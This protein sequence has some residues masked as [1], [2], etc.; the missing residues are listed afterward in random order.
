MKTDQILIVGAGAIGAF[1]GALLAKAGADVSVVCRSD[2]ETVKQ[3]GYQINSTLGRWN[4]KPSQ[5]LQ[6]ASDYQGKATY[7]ILCTKVI[8]EI[9]RVAIIKAAVSINTSIVFIQNGIG[10]EDEL[11]HAFPNNE[12]ISGLAFICSNRTQAGVIEHLA[13]GKLTLGYVSEPEQ[14]S[15]KAEHLSGLITQA[16]INTNTT[17]HIIRNRWLKCVWNA[18]FNPLSVLSDGLLTQDII[19]T[20]ESLV[21]TV[22]QEVCDI[23]AAAGYPLASH[24]IDNNI[25]NTLIMPPYKTSMLLDYEHHR[26]LEVEAILGNTVRIAQH[27]QVACPSL[28]TLYA[29]LTLKLL[30]RE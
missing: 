13:Y 26:P 29:L 14:R 27:H 12:V 28:E 9:D 1:Y 23:A 22:M 17:E 10:I 3:Q 15:H 4:F 2:Y 19:T 16:G 25:N 8:P 5:V 6:S 20:Q 24:S 18:P 30:K 21:R 7:I 11:I